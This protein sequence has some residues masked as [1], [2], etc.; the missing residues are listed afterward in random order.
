MTNNDSISRLPKEHSARTR[1]RRV[2]GIM[3]V[4]IALLMSGVAV[5]QAPTPDAPP[6]TQDGYAVHHTADLGGHI[7]NI[8]GSGAMYDTLINIH[9]G[10]RVLG[11]TFTLHAL[12]GT[13]HTLLDDLTV[14]SNGFGGDP[15]NFAKMDFSKGKLYEFSGNFRRD[16][17]YFDYDLLVNPNTVP[18]VV[19]FGMVNGVPTAASLAWPK[20]NQDQ[21]VSDDVQYRP[22][23]DGHESDH[24]ATLQSDVPVRIL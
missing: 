22:Q 13:K 17:Q 10:P 19:P 16:R 2:A 12:P 14:F 23:N 21:P 15:I 6:V 1:I 9:S 11:Q 3:G 7:A 20:I 24:P 18:Q 4:A 8:S 5:A